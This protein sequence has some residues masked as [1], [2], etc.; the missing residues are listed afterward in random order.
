MTD[1]AVSD[2]LRLEKFADLRLIARPPQKD[3]EHP[4]NVEKCRPSTVVLD[5][6]EAQVDTGHSANCCIIRAVTNEQTIRLDVNF[7]I[8]RREL[9]GVVAMRRH[10]PAVEQTGRR[11][12][13]RSCAGGADPAR[14]YGLWMSLTKSW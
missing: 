5:E 13:R 10:V 8:H 1:L 4:C 9:A 2:R 6:I 12:D 7:R 11:E 3:D 14:R